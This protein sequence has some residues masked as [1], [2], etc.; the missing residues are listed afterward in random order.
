MGA[1]AVRFAMVRPERNVSGVWSVDMQ[2]ARYPKCAR[3]MTTHATGLD[4]GVKPRVQGRFSK[5]R[6]SVPDITRIVWMPPTIFES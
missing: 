5:V 6:R 3:P 1:S 4:L 2:R